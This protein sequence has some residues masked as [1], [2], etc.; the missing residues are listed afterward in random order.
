M[1]AIESVKK[2][3][4]KVAKVR[5]S[6]MLVYILLIQVILSSFAIYLPDM[7]GLSSLVG[8]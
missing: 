2:G 5:R 4:K 6:L 7:G 8:G 1:N 3:I